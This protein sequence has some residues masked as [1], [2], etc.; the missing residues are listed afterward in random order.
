M[1]QQQINFSE[2]KKY[3]RMLFCHNGIRFNEV[4]A[5]QV[6]EYKPP[7]PVV[8]TSSNATIQGTSGLV[9]NGTSHYTA[10][11]SMLFYSKKDYAD[12][13]QYI[14]SQHKYYDEKG[15]IFLGVVGG[16]PDI[17]TLEAE[18]KYLITVPF[19]F[20]KKHEFSNDNEHD[21]IDT[22]NHWA[23]QYIDDMANIGVVS[24]YG[25][26]GEKI[27]EF[28]PNNTTTRAESV[29]LIIRAKKHIDMILR[30]F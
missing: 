18:S 12:W 6:T 3:K 2:D 24:S 13:L 22:N 30:G 16:E 14:G 9:S 1:T 21:F 4:N 7:T 20:I 10:S 8:K 25:I 17:K 5:R 15:S 27:I 23:K 28:R 26:D 19:L 29:A 11:L